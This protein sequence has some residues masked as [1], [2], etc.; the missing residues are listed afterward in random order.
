MVVI[1]PNGLYKTQK[2][3]SSSSLQGSLC[4]PAPEIVPRWPSP[5]AR[6]R[7]SLRGRPLPTQRRLTLTRGHRPLGPPRGLLGTGNSDK[8][9]CKEDVRDVRGDF[10]TSVR[11]SYG[12]NQAS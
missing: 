7:R 8:E 11:N 2:T 10:R 6:S 4:P 3:P 1:A 9:L 5:G 12:Q